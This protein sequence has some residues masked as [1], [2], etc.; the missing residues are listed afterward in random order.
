MNVWDLSL[1]GRDGVGFC[2]VLKR[3][4]FEGDVEGMAGVV[5]IVEYY[6]RYLR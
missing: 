4:G 2:G 1:G 3:G 5:G 6:K